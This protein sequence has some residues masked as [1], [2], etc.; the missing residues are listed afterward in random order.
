M[1]KISLFRNGKLVKVNQFEY[2]KQEEVRKTIKAK[3]ESMDSAKAWLKSRNY[4]LLDRYT[5]KSD[6]FE[7]YRARYGKQVILRTEYIN[8]FDNVA[9][10]AKHGYTKYII[11]EIK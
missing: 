4:R 6:I 8:A 1:K 3:L 11:E 2:P 7:I 9:G 10:I 5:I